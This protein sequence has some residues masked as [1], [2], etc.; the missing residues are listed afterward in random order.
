MTQANDQIIPMEQFERAAAALRVLAH[1]HRLAICAH[2][3]SAQVSVKQVAEHLGLPHNV[4]SQHLNAMKAHGLLESQRQGKTVYYRV[5]DP[6]PL[7]LLEC[8]RRHSPPP[9]DQ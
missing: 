4:V 7:W 8:M 1:P 9:K 6:R 2:L 3:T 5:V